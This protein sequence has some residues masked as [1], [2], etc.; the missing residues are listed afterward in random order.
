MSFQ[1]TDLT[2][3][4]VAKVEFKSD[5]D[6]SNV[7]FSGFNGSSGIRNLLIFNVPSALGTMLAQNLL[8]PGAPDNK[9]LVEVDQAPQMLGG[10]YYE[11]NYV[12]R[13]EILRR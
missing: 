1:I 7:A 9:L 4:Q 5:P 13:I 12:G 10:A 8:F 3:G 2:T 11:A 6:F